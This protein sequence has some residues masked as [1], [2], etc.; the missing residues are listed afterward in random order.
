MDK[1]LKQLEE[2]F[3]RLWKEDFDKGYVGLDS[4]DKYKQFLSKSYQ[5]GNKAGKAETIKK[6]QSIQDLMIKHKDELE[7]LNTN[8]ND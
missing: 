1:Q 8:N 5:L 6:L 3:D 2:A 4:S 7:E